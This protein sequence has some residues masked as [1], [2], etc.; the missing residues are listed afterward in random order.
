MVFLTQYAQL[1]ITPVNHQVLTGPAFVTKANAGRVQKLT[2][3]GL[4]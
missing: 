1:G 3:A 4:R 2:K